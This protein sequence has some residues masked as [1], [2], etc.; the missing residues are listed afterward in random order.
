MFISTRIGTGLGLACLA[1]CSRECDLDCLIRYLV[2]EWMELM[3]SGS[4][5]INV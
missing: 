4:K 5:L 2:D 1:R 3:R